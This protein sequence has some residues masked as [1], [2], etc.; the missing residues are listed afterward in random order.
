MVPFV[1]PDTDWTSC[2]YDGADEAL[3]DPGA[4]ELYNE[5]VYFNFVTGLETGPLGGVMRI[6]L[7][8]N[9]GYAELSLNLP[10]DDGSILFL[11]ERDTSSI[12]DFEVGTRLWRCAGMDLEVVVPTRQWRLRYDG[13]RPR[14]LLDSRQLGLDP[15]AALRASERCRVSVDLVFDGRFPMHALSRSG[16][17]VEGAGAA[18]ARNHYEQFGSV[19]GRI[20][21]DG[22]AAQ[23]T[24]GAFRDHSWGPRDWQ[25]APHSDFTTVLADDGSA[26]VCFAAQLQGRDHFNGVRWSDAGCDP[27]TSFAVASSYAGEVELLEPLAIDIGIG[28]G[29]RKFHYDA[30]VR[31]FL[32]LRHRSGEEVVRI[33]QVLLDFHGPAGHATG[34]TD[35]TRPAS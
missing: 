25:A 19:S 22:R 5:S 32:P 12:D 33:G 31:A 1:A 18:F 4:V 2:R 29:E 26:V 24:G 10:L 28:G 13:D 27:V 15:G 20:T 11:Y 9:D 35:L 17:I 16:D 21:V 6:G 34:W 8:P 3:H 30:T 7:R 23:V 14:R